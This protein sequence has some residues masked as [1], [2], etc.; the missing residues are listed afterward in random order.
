MLEKKKI[1]VVK[2][3]TKYL[4]L[5]MTSASNVRNTQS[6][7]RQNFSHSSLNDRDWRFQSVHTQLLRLKFLE[8]FRFGVLIFFMQ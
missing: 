5:V 7:R 4:F 6:K 1:L 3:D 2:T 8:V